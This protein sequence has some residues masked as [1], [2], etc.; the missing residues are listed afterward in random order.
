MPVFSYFRY[1]SKNRISGSSMFKFLR[2]HQATF[3]RSCIILHSHKC[4]RFP[5]CYFFINI[6]FLSFLKENRITISVCVRLCLVV[7]IKISLMT[8]DIEDLFMCLLAICLSFLENYL[9]KSFVYSDL[10][11]C[12][13]FEVLYSGC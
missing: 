2:T 13:H 9:F 6:F 3:H 10:S 7:W 11:S 4:T 5:I 1:M 12:W 8:S